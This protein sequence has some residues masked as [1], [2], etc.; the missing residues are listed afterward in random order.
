MCAVSYSATLGYSVVR[1]SETVGL[2]V[3]RKVLKQ[4]YFLIPLLICCSTFG[5][6]NCTF[7]ATGSVIA[8]AGYNGD[9]PLIFSLVHRSSRTPIIGLTVELLISMI[10]ITFQFQVLLNYSA[11]VSWMIYLASFCCLMKLKIW[12]HKEYSTKIFQIPIVFVI[13]MKLVCLFTIIMCFYLKPLGC[14]LF[15]LFI[16]LV[17]GFQFVPD[18]YTSCSFLENIHE[19]MVKFLGDKCNLVPITSNDIS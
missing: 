6:T 14:G 3:A 19:K 17:F 2:S 9:L 12:P 4:G 11:F 5:A 8:S 16:I 18:N 15:A 7:Y 13:I 10:F 1:H